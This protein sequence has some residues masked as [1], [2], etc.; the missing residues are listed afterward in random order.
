M[1]YQCFSQRL[2][3]PFRGITNTIRYQSAEAVTADGVHWDIY[4]SNDGLREGLPRSSRIQVSDIRY[5]AWTFDTGLQRGPRCPTDEFMQMERLGDSAY[6]HLLKVHQQAPFPYEDRFELWLLD[7]KDR[8]L[9][10][11]DSATTAPDIKL[12][13]SLVWNPGFNCRK[14]FTSATAD[15][16]GIERTREGALACHLAQYINSLTADRAAAQLFERQPD[17]Q[18]NGLGGAG[19]DPGIGNR[20]LPADSFPAFMLRDAEHDS[21]HS[22]LISDF[23][24]WQAPWLLLLRDLDLETRREYEQYARVQPLKIAQHYQLYPEIVDRETIDAARVEAR[25]RESIPESHL[26]DDSLP[27]FYIELSPEVVD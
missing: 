19:I 9:A 25:L 6:E 11:I 12:D 3:N 22:R 8:P 14:T 26:K 18:G 5:G 16:L 24:C 4:V 13:Q 10:L 21:L 23:F 17:G 15:E 1:A 20:V 27:S 2:L 7:S